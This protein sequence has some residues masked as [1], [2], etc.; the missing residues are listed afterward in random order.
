VVD[1]PT[2]RARRR[3]RDDRVTGHGQRPRAEHL[4]AGF[5]YAEL[6]GDPADL[7]AETAPDGTKVYVGGD[8]LA[9]A[10]GSEV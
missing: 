10:V 9:F 4:V 1:E 8:G 5:A 6:V 7:P 3:H 2:R